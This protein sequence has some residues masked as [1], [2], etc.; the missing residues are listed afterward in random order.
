MG[1]DSSD[2][3]GIGDCRPMREISPAENMS[4]EVS[5]KLLPAAHRDIIAQIRSQKKDGTRQKPSAQLLDRSMLLNG[6]D[7]AAILDAIA[8]LVDENLAGRSEMCMQFADLLHR[9]LAYLGL[10]A[11]P[12]I[13]TCIYYNAGEEIYRWKHAWVRVD[14]E[15][16][17]GNVDILPENPMVPAAI[18]VA[19]Y[20]GPITAIPADRRLR[21][22]HG[23][24]FPPDNDV[25]EIW[26]PDLRS[27]LDEYIDR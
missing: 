15:V 17:D 9:A 16:I 3:T 1:S 7:R 19:P 20:W 6:P 22:D 14:R 10:S 23:A 25:S 2:R 18:T 11:R 13:G 8:G 12:V 24:K 21:E 4:V 27:W 5:L 26:W